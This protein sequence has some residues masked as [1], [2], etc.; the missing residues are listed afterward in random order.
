VKRS[1]LAFLAVSVFTLYDADASAGD[2][3][4]EPGPPKRQVTVAADAS[5]P[6]YGIGAAHG[7][8]RL[9]PDV[10]LGLWLGGGS[11]RRDD[12]RGYRAAWERCGAS[13][14]RNAFIGAALQA[15]FYAYGTFSGPHSLQLGAEA[16]FS[17]EWG[18]ESRTIVT[19]GVVLGYKLVT[20]AGFT[21]NPQSTLGYAI[22][23]EPHRVSSRFVLGFGWSF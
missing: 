19:P 7:E 18:A 5:H 15:I 3:C 8:V 9:S 21:F 6:L 23:D 10:G 16:A 4:E 14:E 17:Q 2:L 22:G 12:I 11:V 1:L 20:A 13:C